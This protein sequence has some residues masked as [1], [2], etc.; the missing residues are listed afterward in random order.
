MSASLFGQK[1]IQ[2]K[3]V[4]VQRFKARIIQL[5]HKPRVIGND[6]ILA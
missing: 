2:P 5:R 4:E 1:V 6:Q 3:V